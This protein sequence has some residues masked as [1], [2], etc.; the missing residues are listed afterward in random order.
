VTRGRSR[1]RG[2]EF[3]ALSLPNGIQT[4]HD[5]RAKTATKRVTRSGLERTRPSST[6][7]SDYSNTKCFSLTSRS[8]NGLLY[9]NQEG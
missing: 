8:M 6:T 1:F 9:S 5:K 4:S 3:G 2:M 7:Y